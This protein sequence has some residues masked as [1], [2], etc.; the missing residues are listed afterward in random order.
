[1]DKVFPMVTWPNSTERIRIDSVTISNLRMDLAERVR[2]HL[3]RVDSSVCI[4]IVASLANLRLE[5]ERFQSQIANDRNFQGGWL[6][7]MPA[8]DGRDASACSE[9]KSQN[10][11]TKHQR[12]KQRI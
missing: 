8:F 1:M 7:Q 5:I 6:S 10:A 2:T 9:A 3:L 12:Q 4:G 11:R